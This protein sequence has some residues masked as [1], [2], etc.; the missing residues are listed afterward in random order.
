MYSIILIDNIT[1]T[2]ELNALAMKR[3]EQTVYTVI[4]TPQYVSTPPLPNSMYNSYRPELYNHARSG[5]P[6]NNFN[7]IV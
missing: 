1:P 4:E 7:N 3:G 2:V 5:G 6:Y